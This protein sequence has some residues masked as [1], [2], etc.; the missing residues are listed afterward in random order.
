[1]TGVRG[2]H[3]LIRKNQSFILFRKKQEF[4]PY[5]QESELPTISRSRP[6]FRLQSL[7]QKRGVEDK[8]CAP[9]TPQPFDPTCAGLLRSRRVVPRLTHLANLSYELHS[10][11]LMLDSTRVK[12]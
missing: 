10:G 4:H 6:E 2:T 11:R 8:V 1:M 9:K 5:L 3:T 7:R 12:M